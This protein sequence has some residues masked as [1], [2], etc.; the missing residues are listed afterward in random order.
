MKKGQE[1]YFYSEDTLQALND[2]IGLLAKMPDDK[3]ILRNPVTETDYIPIDVIENLFDRLVLGQYST[4]NF[5]WV[6]GKNKVCGTIEL[7]YYHPI[8]GYLLRRVGGSAIEIPH[9]TMVVGEGKEPVTF[10]MELAVPAL[11]SLCTVSAIRKV[12]TALGRSLNRPILDMAL[13]EQIMESTKMKEAVRA[14]ES[15]SSL[16][17]LQE[18]RE[19]LV[20]K[21]QPILEKQEFTMFHQMITEKLMDLMEKDKSNG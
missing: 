10:T 15:I 11:L 7:E 20:E 13:K 17:E 12:G 5:K 3:D 16:K 4:Q 14:L 6:I 2:F 1:G 19:S 18:T 21:Y 9:K 8:T